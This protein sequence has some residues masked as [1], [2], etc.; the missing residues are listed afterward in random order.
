MSSIEKGKIDPRRGTVSIHPEVPESICGCTQL[1]PHIRGFCICR[2]NQQ[3]I[4][5]YSEKNSRKF[6]KRNM[7]LLCS[8][9]YLHNIYI[10]FA[11]IYIAFTLWCWERLRAGRE[12]DNIGRDGWMASL[13]QWARVWATSERVKDR[14]A[15]HAAVHGVAES[16]TT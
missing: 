2:F 6:K 13:T 4:S 5:K 11:I 12:G 1:A 8:G 16:N 7:N 9:N 14:E 3:M 10:I 15:W